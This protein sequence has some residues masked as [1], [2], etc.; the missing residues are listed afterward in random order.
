[1]VT[2][3]ILEVVVVV[4]L[5]LVLEGVVVTNGVVLL[6]VTLVVLI[7]VVTLV[8]VTG[9]HPN[10]VTT[11]SNNRL[12]INLFNLPPILSLAVFQPQWRLSTAPIKLVGY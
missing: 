10:A 7:K 8:V 3:T 4:V 5:V 2:G 11:V 12:Q 1:V 9:S 6:I